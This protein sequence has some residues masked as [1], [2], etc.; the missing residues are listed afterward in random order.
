MRPLRIAIISFDPYPHEVRSK[1]LAEAAADYGAEVDA[2]C[3]SPGGDERLPEQHNGVRIYP[4]PIVRKPEAPLPW[5]T[6]EWLW[7]TALAAVKVARLHQTRHYDVIHVHNMP[8]FLVFAALVP[9]LQG[10]RV[11]L[12]VQDVSPE[13]MGAKSGKRLRR[14]LVALATVQE[15]A[16]TAFADQVVTV[17]WPFE[18]KLLDRS[19]PAAKLHVIINSADPHIFPESRRF[20]PDDALRPVTPP[21]THESPFIVMYWGTVARRNGLMTAVRAL[22]LALPQAPHMRLDIMAAG[23]GDEIPQLKRLAQ[24]LGVADSVRITDPVAAEHIIDFIAHG[25]V[26]IIPYAVDGFADL[27]L[28]TKAYE[29]AWL[30]RP[31]VASSTP[32][33]CSMFRPESIAL[34]QSGDPQSFA[35]ALVDLYH[36]PDKRKA[37]VENA[38]ADYEPYRWERA[39]ERYHDLLAALTEQTPIGKVAVK[40]MRG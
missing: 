10:A 28:P 26:G 14:L 31:I 15:R 11:I 29:M 2:I 37:M 4:L 35:D 33:I 30:R 23:R 40:Q 19:V 9:K 25:D 36:H 32:A 24:E 13:L 18:R 3:L 38:A 8:D 6:M 1:R 22:A 16:S 34:C 12:D 20:A 21:H 27:V 17:G 7:F 5:T 39:R